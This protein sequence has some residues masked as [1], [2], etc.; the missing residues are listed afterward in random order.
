M[1]WGLLIQMIGPTELD[2]SCDGRKRQTEVVQGQE[3]KSNSQ[4]WSFLE[5]MFVCEWGER[6]QVFLPPKVNKPPEKL[7][8]ETCSL[9][10]IW[11]VWRHRDVQM[12]M[13]PSPSF[14]Q[15]HKYYCVCNRCGKLSYFKYCNKKRNNI[16]ILTDV[17]IFLS[18]FYAINKIEHCI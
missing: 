12:L 1:G 18:E 10:L 17:S 11:K 16:C 8:F 7:Y 14:L 3:K 5:L 2:L 9:G 15:W 6:C 13:F 4:T